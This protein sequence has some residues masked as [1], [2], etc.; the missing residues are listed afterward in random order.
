VPA[1][2]RDFGEKAVNFFQ[3]IL[4]KSVF[5]NFCSFAG[6]T[7]ALA[8]TVTLNSALKRLILTFRVK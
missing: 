5:A 1:D 3:N 8:I 6:Y 4:R 7:P 2:I